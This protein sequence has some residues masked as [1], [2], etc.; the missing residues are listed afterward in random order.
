MWNPM[1]SCSLLKRA[2][3]FF[4]VLTVQAFSLAAPQ[5]TNHVPAAKP[6]VSK[7]PQTV[8]YAFGASLFFQDLDGSPPREEKPTLPAGGSLPEGA[9]IEYL[10]GSRDGRTLAFAVDKAVYFYDTAS[11]AVTPVTPKDS[12]KYLYPSISP[13]GLIVSCRPYRANATLCILSRSGEV[14]DLG[15]S[16]TGATTSRFT[17]DG[18]TI[19][20]ANGPDFLRIPAA[21]GEAERVVRGHYIENFSVNAQGLIIASVPFDS[22][23]VKPALVNEAGE[24]TTL[25][26]ES[27]E[28]NNPTWSPDGMSVVFSLRQRDG[29][30][31][32]AQGLYIWKDIKTQKEIRK[33]SDAPSNDQSGFVWR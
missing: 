32:N 30:E 29:G 24:V 12:V 31:S 18:Q 26:F 22:S 25:A 13:D 27:N 16:T 15:A 2:T 3:L 17:T 1:S 4:I 23:K 10:S 21:G 20:F 6:E 14:R 8:I 33:V 9:E 19:Y 11:K 5:V 7:P 28:F